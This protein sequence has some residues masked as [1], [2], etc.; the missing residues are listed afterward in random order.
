MDHQVLA[1]VPRAF[2]DVRLVIHKPRFPTVDDT[3]ARPQIVRILNVPGH[4]LSLRRRA[5]LGAGVPVL[6]CAA[7]SAIQ[8]FHHV[9]LFIAKAILQLRPYGKVSRR[10]RHVFTVSL[11]R[12]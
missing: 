9:F 1:M 12:N 3:P 2:P 7:F 10:Q 4:F 11:F 8:V 5:E 6:G